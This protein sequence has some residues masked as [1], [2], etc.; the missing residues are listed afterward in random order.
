MTGSE[1]SNPAPDTSINIPHDMSGH[2][3][4][5][6][7]RND[8]NGTK[9]LHEVARAARAVNTSLWN[10][11]QAM[12]RYQAAI[13]AGIQGSSGDAAHQAAQPVLSGLMK[14]QEELNSFAGMAH[15]QGGNFDEHA[16]SLVDVPKDKPGF[17]SRVGSSIN[18]F[19]NDDPSN[20]MEEYN[21]ADT[22]NKGAFK[23]YGGLTQQHAG[24]LPGEQQPT[25]NTFDNIAIY[26]PKRSPGHSYGGGGHTGGGS[27]VDSDGGSYGGLGSGGPGSG[28]SAGQHDTGVGGLGRGGTG[29]TGGGTG[30]GGLAGGYPG[31]PGA[32]GTHEPASAVTS[33]TGYTASTPSGYG[34][35]DG[36]GP[37]GYSSGGFG[38]DGS[39]GGIGGGMPMGGGLGASGA[40]GGGGPVSGRD[41]GTGG[42]Q[43]G[44]RTGAGTLGAAG[45]Q[46]A[47]AGRASATS[48]SG[49]PG[50]GGMPMGGS[51]RKGE[52]TRSISWPATWSTRT[53]EARSS[54]MFR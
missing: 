13:A 18:P 36:L 46:G 48:A 17:W 45:E 23:A 38:R 24:G 34:A 10:A 7:M 19:E 42:M 20:D 6:Q 12:R 27:G 33:P 50:V 22:H 31:A 51:G 11:E 49:R 41:A 1:G 28:G 40:F 39:A 21:K 15:A 47:V 35:G 14:S 43:G 9:S 32:P 16:R 2:T 52:T 37:G 44:A 8:V 53:T 54:V 25:I 29:G 3:I 26:D 4:Y 30:P 5:D